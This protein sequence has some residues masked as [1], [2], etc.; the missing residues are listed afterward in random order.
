MGMGKQWDPIPKEEDIDEKAVQ[1]K[2]MH[3]IYTADETSCQ[4]AANPENNIP[5]PSNQERDWTRR[6]LLREGGSP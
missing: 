3:S 5:N 4:K 1:R 2:V 6:I